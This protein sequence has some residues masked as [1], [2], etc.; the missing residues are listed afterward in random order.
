MLASSAD[1]LRSL[2]QLRFGGHSLPIEIAIKWMIQTFHVY[3]SK[4]EN[5]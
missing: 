3:G 4:L 2:V 1:I 5:A